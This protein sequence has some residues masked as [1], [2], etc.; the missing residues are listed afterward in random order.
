MR[1]VTDRQKDRHTDTG[2]FIICPM[3]CYSNGTDNHEAY[4]HW[5]AAFNAVY[6]VLPSG[7]YVASTKCLAEDFCSSKIKKVKVTRSAHRI[8]DIYAQYSS[9]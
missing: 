7:H 6:P 5:K 4:T 2:D 1:E 9:G 3:L 8:P